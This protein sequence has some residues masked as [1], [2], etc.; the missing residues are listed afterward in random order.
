MITDTIRQHL[1]LRWRSQSL[2]SLAS[3]SGVRLLT[4]SRFINGT[5]G[6][7]GETLDALA[8][9]LGLE[10]VKTGQHPTMNQL[11]HSELS[12]EPCDEH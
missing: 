4:L 2:Y 11:E 8:A 9:Y 10:L 6:A 5:H 7:R 3:E 1:R 12:Y